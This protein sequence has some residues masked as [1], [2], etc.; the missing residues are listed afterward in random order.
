VLGID[1]QADSVALQV[2][3]SGSFGWADLEAIQ[4]A[5]ATQLVVLPVARMLA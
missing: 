3:V 1:D 2:L 5:G 4:H